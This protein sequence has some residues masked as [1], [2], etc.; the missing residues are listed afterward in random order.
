MKEDLADRDLH[1]FVGYVKSCQER[2]AAEE[3]ASRGIS[4]YVPVQKVRSRWSDRVKIVD[5]LVI[6]G[7]IFVRCTFSDRLRM[8]ESVRMVYGYITDGGPHNP[9]V[10]RDAEMETFVRMVSNSSLE[11]S[12]GPQHLSA[13]DRVRVI[14]GPLTGLECELVKVAD[15][16]CLAARLNGVGTMLMEISPESVKK[17]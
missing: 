5:R 4:T 1:W 12:R 8:L 3:F 7:L 15:K 16:A 13:G 2:R 9:A 10:V 6:P 11:L 14:D 17:I